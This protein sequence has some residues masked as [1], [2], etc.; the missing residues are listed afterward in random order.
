MKNKRVLDRN[1]VLEA[2]ARALEPLEFVHALWE[3]G[4]VSWGRI[5]RWSDIDVNVDADDDK[6]PEV[7][8]TVEK[9]LTSL[10]RIEIKYSIPYP[11]SHNYAQAFYRLADASPF[12]FIDLAIFRHSAEDKFLEPEIHGPAV[13][14]FNKSNVKAAGPI[15]RDAHVARII[16][17]AGRLRLRYG[18]FGCFVEKEIRRGNSIEALGNYQRIVLDTL[19]EVLRMRYF[20]LHYSFATRYVHY[21]LP[22]KVVRRFEKLSFV[23]DMDDLRRKN[24]T[25]DRWLQAEFAAIDRRSLTQRMTTTCAPLASPPA[26]KRQK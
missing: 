4:A 23:A 12:M 5:D 13:F 21:E 10:S 14:L 1:E 6:T 22:P 20:P 16:E 25:A 18:M 7:F 8:E 26:D 17:R 2:I 3:A 24:R 11:P 9:A 15:D 19:L